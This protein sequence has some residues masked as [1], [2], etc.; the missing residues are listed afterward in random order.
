M[1]FLS[2]FYSNFITIFSFFLLCSLD[3]RLLSCKHF[4]TSSFWF[5]HFNVLLYEL[6]FIVSFLLCNGEWEK[7]LL[8][9]VF[10]ISQ[11]EDLASVFSLINRLEI[12]NFSRGFSRAPQMHAILSFAFG[13]VP[14]NFDMV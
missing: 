8:C 5:L 14:H 10:L 11:L 12:I 6:M 3:Q 2:P 9:C 13:S 1:P 7:Y 4:E